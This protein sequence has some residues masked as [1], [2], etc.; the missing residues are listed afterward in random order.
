MTEIPTPIDSGDFVPP[1]SHGTEM[2]PPTEVR[3]EEAIARLGDLEPGTVVTGF[4]SEVGVD[5]FADNVGRFLRHQDAGRFRPRLTL[6]PE[7]YSLH[8]QAGYDG[9]RK[10]TNKPSEVLRPKGLFLGKFDNVRVVVLGEGEPE[11]DMRR[12]GFVAGADMMVTG[13]GN[14]GAVAIEC[15]VG[16]KLIDPKFAFPPPIAVRYKPVRG[17]SPEEMF[18]AVADASRERAR[19]VVVRGLR[20]AFPA[21]LPTLGR[22]R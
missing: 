14:Q 10:G 11:G 6:P 2:V 7:S 16:S 3:W 17:K 8:G 18:D 22:R 4:A 5:L 9:W 20:T 15:N 13:R 19:D 1:A 12:Y 21:G